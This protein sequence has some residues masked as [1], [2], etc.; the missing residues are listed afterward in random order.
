[1]VYVILGVLVVGGAYAASMGLVLWS[2]HIV[3]RIHARRLSSL[4]QIK[5]ELRNG[6]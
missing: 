3:E 4:R 1:M 6:R 5:R 2:R